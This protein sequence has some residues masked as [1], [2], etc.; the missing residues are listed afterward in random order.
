VAN[1]GDPGLWQ[2]LADWLEEHE[3]PRRAELLRRHRELIATCC[4]PDLHPARAQQQ[5]RMVHLLAEGVRPCVPRLTLKVASR[6]EMAFAWIPP[7]SFLMGS[8]ESEE[9][10]DDDESQHRVTLTRGFW[11][12]VVPV[13]QPQWRAVM[14]ENPSGFRGKDRPVDRVTWEDC[15]EFCRRLG[16]RVGQPFRLPTEA[17]WEYACRAGTTSSFFIG[18]TITTK[19]ANFDYAYGKTVRGYLREKTTPVGTFPLNA[20]GLFDM[21]GNASEWCQDWY[22]DYTPKAGQDPTGPARGMERVLRGGSWSSSPQNCRAAS[23]FQYTPAFRFYPFG[24][25]VFVRLS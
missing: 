3:D 18:Q 22:A 19:L 8:P 4:E 12:G 25:R 13:T 9:G 1:P 20:W 14:G 23:R 15:Q 10:R 21:H 5:A 7:G 16:E 17:E 24:V 11:L 2:I 6:V